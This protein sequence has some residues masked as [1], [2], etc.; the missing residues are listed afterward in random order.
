V[1]SFFSGEKEGCPSNPYLVA[2]AHPRI[3]RILLSIEGSHAEGGVKSYATI[4]A[5]QK[6]FFSSKLL[7][8]RKKKR[9]KNILVPYPKSG[10]VC[11]S[12]HLA[13]EDFL[14]ECK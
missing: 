9:K 13:S 8:E 5:F 3:L 4:R 1:N 7:V 11:C 14:E 6:L 12:T 2:S 10:H